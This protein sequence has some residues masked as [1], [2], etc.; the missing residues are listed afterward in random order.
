MGDVLSTVK[1]SL[2][3]LLQEESWVYDPSRGVGYRATYRGA[4][5]AQMRDLA[6]TYVNAGISCVL[7]YNQGDTATL[8]IDNT[9]N[10]GSGAGDGLASTVDTWQIVGN[11]LSMDALSHPALFNGIAAA[12]PSAPLSSIYGVIN[13]MRAYLYDKVPEATAFGDSG[14][15]NGA[16]DICKR[17]Y[18]LVIVGQDEYRRAQY[19]LRHTTNAPNRYSV[20][21]ADFGVEQIYSTAELLTECQDGA[22]WYYPMPGRLAYKISAIP[23][24]TAQTNYLW[25]WLKSPSTEITA[26][27]NRIEI[28]TEFTLEQWSTDFYTPY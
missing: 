10:S 24:P 17:F 2:A 26:A 4:S 16:P 28:T 14:L 25:G 27:N 19:V 18:R 5:Q 15:L 11:D 21:V 6:Q 3:A 13:Q 12:Y 8:E 23:V 1:G 7:T 22:L 9:T 20:N